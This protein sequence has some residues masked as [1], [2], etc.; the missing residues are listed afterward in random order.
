MSEAQTGTKGAA[1]DRLL[2]P[3][4]GSEEAKAALPYAAALATPGTEIVL[5]TVVP[6][7]GE[8]IGAGGELAVSDDALASVDADRARAEL[9]TI[10]AGLRQT[11][12]TVQTRVG[13]GEPA[14]TIIATAN[15]L[16]ASFIVLAT[17]GRGAVGRL[18]F[19]SVADIVAR[20][21]RVPVMVVRASEAV[22]G[23]VG[24]T[25]LLVLL[26]GSPRA[27]ESLPVATAI[28]RRLGTPIHLIRVVNPI[29]LLPPSIGLA[30]AVPAEVYAETQDQIE[31]DA[32]DYLD[33]VA[34]RLR[35]QGFPVTTHVLTGTPAMSI[36]EVTQPGDV[37]VVSSR[38]HSGILRWILGSVAEQLVRED[39]APVILAPASEAAEAG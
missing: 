13:S 39:Q 38:E 37:T 30:Q 35:E 6:A 11:G 24:I 27:E 3:L 28:S 7:G 23:P 26:D 2:V 32:R 22:S 20:D 25:R 29:D 5:L 10:A 21:A 17:R 18:I 8:V 9:D 4:D 15:D 19:G 33:A 31:Q 16:G 36:I 12:H 34:R 1:G 14:A